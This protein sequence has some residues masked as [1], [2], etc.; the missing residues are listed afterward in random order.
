[1]PSSFNLGPFLI[2]SYGLTV[3]LAIFVGFLLIWLRAPSFGIKKDEILD[4]PLFL[5]IPTLF[6]A[7]LYHVLHYWDYYSK[8]PSQIIAF[9][10]GGLAIWGALIGGFLTLIFYSRIK[11]IKPLVLLDLLAPGV[12]L[13]QSLGRLGNFFNL[14]A[15]GPPTNLPWK[16]YIPPSNRP[17]QYFQAEFFHPTFF[18]EAAASLL[19]FLILIFF[20]QK[21]KKIPGLTFFLYVI[22]YL[23]ARFGLEF[24]RVDTWLLGEIK[25]AQILSFL[26][27]LVGAGF[28]VLKLWP[29]NV[30]RKDF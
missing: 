17:P 23:I 25:M 10:Q 13:A 5:V 2:H 18:Y 6:G 22:L 19:I 4:L 3:A 12:V 24:L 28:F 29:I 14:E 20:A 21:F 9:W 15:F 11:K 26:G 16:I 1:M 30:K 7:R 27:I 8:N